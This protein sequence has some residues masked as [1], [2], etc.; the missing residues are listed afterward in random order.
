MLVMLLLPS[1]ALLLSI[2]MDTPTNYDAP[3]DRYDA[4]EDLYDEEVKDTTADMHSLEAQFHPGYDFPTHS[5][6]IDF[7]DSLPIQTD[8]ALSVQ[9]SDSLPDLCCPGGPNYDCHPL[10]NLWGVVMAIT[11]AITQLLQKLFLTIIDLPFPAT[12][13]QPPNLLRRLLK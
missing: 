12:T 8:D 13:A 7:F 9:S 4:P 1:L 6:A 5:S 11:M 2:Q 10:F 3:E